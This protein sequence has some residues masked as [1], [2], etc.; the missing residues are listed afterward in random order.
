MH[1]CEGYIVPDTPK[2]AWDYEFH[3]SHGE[4]CYFTVS[5]FD[6]VEVGPGAVSITLRDADGDVEGS[7]VIDRGRVNW[8][9]SA[10]R[11]LE[12]QP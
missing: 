4:P 6:Q 7:Q 9:K 12:D 3:F 1:C 5:E 10:R 2:F 8:W 11:P